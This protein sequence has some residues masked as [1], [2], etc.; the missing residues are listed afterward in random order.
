MK[1]SKN[2]KISNICNT[3]IIL[4]LIVFVV[5]I[6]L[7]VVCGN[8][9]EEEKVLKKADEIEDVDKINVEERAIEEDDRLLQIANSLRF[10]FGDGVLREVDFNNIS[11]EAIAYFIQNVSD[12][13]FGYNFSDDEKLVFCVEGEN[14]IYTDDIFYISTSK[15][16]NAY[17]LDKVKYYAENNFDRVISLDNFSGELLNYFKYEDDKDFIV[18]IN[19]G[20]NSKYLATSV[21][22]IEI[23]DDIYSITYTVVNNETNEKT[24][25]K[26]DFVI[27]TDALINEISFEDIRILSFREVNE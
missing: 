24:N 7:G 27:L 11:D 16:N 5:S 1:K 4:S 22:Y 20:L 12:F 8:K 2:S 9:V 6:V 10:F 25:Y 14:C 19:S 26:L 21:D 15:R 23:N 18:D 3:G 13:E 17:L